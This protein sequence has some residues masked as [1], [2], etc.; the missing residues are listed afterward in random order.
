[1]NAIQI[2]IT[3]TLILV[4]Y[5]Y[6]LCKKPTNN[7]ENEAWRRM[8]LILVLPLLINIVG[9]DIYNIMT[10]PDCVSPTPSVSNLPDN[11]LRYGGML[12]SRAV[13]IQGHI[14]PL[15]AAFV[16]IGCLQRK[17][18]SSSHLSA[19]FSQN[20]SLCVIRPMP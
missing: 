8:V 3:M 17:R 16:L 13:S 18:L 14:M 5:I 1:M 11:I 20:C 2:Y 19:L 10:A 4:A 7:N 12:F 9:N 6:V 15:Y